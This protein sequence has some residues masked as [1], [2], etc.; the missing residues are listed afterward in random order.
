MDGLATRIR[1][2]L[3][4]LEVAADGG[5]HVENN[6]KRYF[7]LCVWHSE[8]TAS[9]ELF[10]E[11]NKGFCHS[12]KKSF[13]SIDLWAHIHNCS[14]SEAFAT[15]KKKFELNEDKP[16][17]KEQ[18][19]VVATYDYRDESGTLVY[20][21]VRKKPKAF[22]QRRPSPAGGWE[23]NLRGINSLPYRLREL[24]DAVKKSEIIYIVEGEKDVNALIAIGLTATCNSGGAGKWTQSHSKYFS[25]GTKAV[26]LPDNDE[27]GQ[28][29][30]KIVAQQLFAQ[31]CQIKIINLPGLKAKGDVS[32][33]IGS[34]HGLDELTQ[35]VKN[36][37][38][39]DSANILI[40]EKKQ[41]TGYSSGVIDRTDVGNAQRLSKQFGKIIR[42]NY[43]R[44]KWYIWDGS[45]WSMDKSGEIMRLAKRTAKN[46]YIEAANIPDD[47]ESKAMAKHAIA[48]LS[49]KKLKDM[50]ELAKSE[51]GITVTVDDM[52]Q[53]Q[54]LL[55]VNNGV[56]DLKTGE[57]LTHEPGRLMSKLV[58]I[59]YD[60]NSDCPQWKCFL[61][62]IMAGN[63]NLIWFLQKAIGYALTGSVREQCLFFLY[64]SG[65]NGKSTF[66]NTVQSLL[67]DYAMA[68]PIDTLLVKQMDNGST[69]DLA[70]LKGAR[71]VS[72]VE[73][74]DGKRLAEAKIKQLTGADGVTARFLY[75]ESFTYTPTFKL[76]IG[77]NHKPVIRGTDFAIW[78]RIRLIPFDVTISDSE[79]DPDLP[80]KL[81]E[82]LPGILYWAVEGCLAWQAEGL[83]PPEEVK[84][85]TEGYRSEMDILAGFLEDCCTIEPCLFE[86]A[87]NLYSAYTQWCADS[88]ETPI[89]ART[90]GLRMQERGFEKTR[91]GHK[92]AR[93][94]KGLNLNLDADRADRA[95]TYFSKVSRSNENSK[96]LLE[97]ASKASAFKSSVCTSEGEGVKK[98]IEMFGGQVYTT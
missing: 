66:L 40:K 23:Y 82:E 13:D 4:I 19:K 87:N 18:A 8:K 22:I 97:S 96:S 5:L 85:A 75:G 98:A 70:R 2:Q 32:D 50:V 78:R 65:R 44:G 56:V 61:N 27:A 25:A 38:I 52:D 83:E 54:W 7:S 26:I 89:L 3:P 60:T 1:A 29:H 11:Q 55:N 71:F 80:D 91:I 14:L 58:P 9:M 93:G 74:E 35:L 46:I 16:T 20:Q 64:G 84:M 77:T 53:D 37:E 67:S 28:N 17:K 24:L 12:C 76:F 31:G 92:Q 51:P 45:R 95:D 49:H 62:K 36:T 88:G 94:Y 6:G 21:V 73:A 90:F 42:F 33:W 15:F 69:N 72:S 10:P 34:G 39:W 68:T 81:L 63:D 59:N 43:D 79:V 41:E 47:Y 57:L 48:S 86:T 30:A